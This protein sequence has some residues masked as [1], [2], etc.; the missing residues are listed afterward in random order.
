MLVNA[1]NNTNEFILP[2]FFTVILQILFRVLGG[3]LRVD[4][5]AARASVIGVRIRRTSA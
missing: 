3:C 2:V 4:P 1:R 5:L